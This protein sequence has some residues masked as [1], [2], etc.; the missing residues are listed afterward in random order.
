[1]GDGTA[2]GAGQATDCATN[3]AAS[4]YDRGRMTVR[5]NVING[6]NGLLQ[7]CALYSISLTI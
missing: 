2:Q 4:Q 1:M 3:T 6:D 5:N 7:M